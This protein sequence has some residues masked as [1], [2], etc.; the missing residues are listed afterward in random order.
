VYNLD[1]KVRV[2][3]ILI[4]NERLLLVKQRVNDSRGWSLPGGTLEPGETIEECI[5]REMKE[6]TGLNTEIEKLLYICDR[7]EKERHVVHITLLWSYIQNI[8]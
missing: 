5:I 1:I 7:I 8:V 3:G 4:E 6:E 2:T